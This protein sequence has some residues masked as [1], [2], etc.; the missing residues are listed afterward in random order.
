M[1]EGEKKLASVIS[2]AQ[3]LLRAEKDTAK[4]TATLIEE[5]VKLAASVVSPEEPSAI[6]QKAATVA[7]IQ[8]FSHWIG[9]IATLKDVTGH[10]DWLVEARKKDW[11]Y[12]RRYRDY[13]EQRLSTDVVDAL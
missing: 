9:K 12:W 3:T 5:K 7:L 2:I 8:R 10:V 6:D 13:L 4:I 11:L 1:T